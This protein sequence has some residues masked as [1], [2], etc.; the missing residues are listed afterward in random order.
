MKKP[1]Y[2]RWW[3]IAIV[4]VLVLGAI[5]SMIDGDDAD[6][7]KEPVANSQAED[8]GISEELYGDIEQAYT[9]IGIDS[10]KDLA[11][12]DEGYQLTYEDYYVTASIGEDGTL[13]S[14]MSG[15]VVFWLDGEVTKKVQDVFVTTEQYVSLTN[16]SEELVKEQLKS[17]STAEF[18]GTILE[19]DEWKITKNQNIYFVNSWVDSQNSFGAMIRSDFIIQYEW[20]GT[21][22]TEPVVVDMA[23]E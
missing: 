18:P 6:K 15:Q 20:D 2:K 21:K 16:R 14:I 1:I 22:D 3:F 4:V 19:R 13:S 11:K 9:D 5:G 10:I 17:P 7:V 12:V 8:L 23:I